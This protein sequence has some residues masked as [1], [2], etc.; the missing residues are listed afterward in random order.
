MRGALTLASDPFGE[1]PLYWRSDGER[2][3]FASTIGAILRAAPEALT[4]DEDVLARYVALGA[5]ARARPRASFA[6]SERLPRRPPAALAG[7]AASSCGRY[8]QPAPVAAA[9]QRAR[10]RPQRCGSC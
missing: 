8:W 5:D 4:V 3:V 7:A 6:A 2:I 9:G 1:K 10:P